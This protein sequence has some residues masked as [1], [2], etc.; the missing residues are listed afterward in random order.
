VKA[1]T[2]QDIMTNIGSGSGMAPR[3]RAAGEPSVLLGT[4]VHEVPPAD[5]V[6]V[7]DEHGAVAG[8]ITGAELARGLQQLMDRDFW[9]QPSVNDLMFSVF[10]DAL[11]AMVVV[12][13]R[14]II[15]FLN[16]AYEVILKV[17]RS[18]AIG[19][20]VTEMLPN[21]RMHIVAQSGVAEV[22]RPFVV[23]ND[24]FIV[25]RHPVFMGKQLVGAVGRVMFRSFKELKSVV[26]RLDQLQKRVDYYERQFTRE[27]RAKYTLADMVGDGPAMTRLKTLA[28]RAA[29]SHA[30]VLILGE[31]GT[32]K[33]LLAHAMHSESPR[34]EHPF[35]KVNCAA[36][37]K[38]LLESELFGYEAGAFSGALKSGKPGKFEQANKGTIFLDEIADM[39]MDMQAKVL[40]AIQEREIQKVGSTK[41]THIDVR[42]VA[43]TNKDLVREVAE[44]RF[45]EDLY[46]RLN[47]IELQMPPLRERLED[48]PDLVRSRM[49][50][51]CSEAG[52]EVK[53]LTPAAMAALQSYHWPGNVRELVHTLERVVN[54]VDADVIDWADL[55]PYVGLRR[56]AAAAPEPAAGPA[57]PLRE[58][59]EDTER[60]LIIDALRTSGGNKLQAAKRLGIHRSVLYRKMAK[61]SIQG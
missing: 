48:V 46:Y 57:G 20:H 35:V 53:I 15:L 32:G 61:W 1:L 16:R 4:P 40:R 31:C 25:E 55:P 7:T 33:E 56:P 10:E 21:S 43:A 27:A 42:I 51:V 18:W 52:V 24:E 26:D 44:G 19:R 23:G 60:Q 59:V 54:M 8:S 49:E 14:G 38:D 6:W 5:L 47:V 34:A 13:T 58:R 36:I 22:G 30:T 12:D 2:A 39:P 3:P 45:R 17:N 50:R 28:R 29:K 9:F 37:P 41:E 11:D